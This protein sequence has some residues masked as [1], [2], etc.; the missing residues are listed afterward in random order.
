M[1]NRRSFLQTTLTAGA[2]L[3][4]GIGAH[5]QSAAPR[6]AGGFKLKY[7]PHFGMFKASAGDDL[8]D[9]LKFAADEGFTAWEDNGMAGRPVD[10]QEKVAA[11]MQRLGMTMGVFVAMADFKN[12]T[13]ASPAE[14]ARAKILADMRA[15]LEVAKRVN[16]KW[17]TVVPGCYDTKLAWD[18]QLANV[19]DNFR[20]CAEI[21]EPAGLVMVM[22]PLNTRR[23]HPGVFLQDVPQGFAICRAVNSPSCKILYDLYHAQIQ[24]GNLIPNVD[25][26][27]SETPYFQVGDNP[28]R[29]EPGTGEINYRN[30]FRHLHA[31]GFAGVVGMEHGNA[32]PGKD[33]ERAVIQAYRDADAF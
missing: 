21:C 26:A 9:Q 31:K 3:L 27:W 7:A 24:V 4:A 2:G 19:I 12:V 23:D 10:V 17:T 5:A 14:D 1:I 15:A 28:G 6:A 18:F 33:G 16:A 11:A 25:L 20:R 13:F 32:R 30:V 29:K 22:E 8:V